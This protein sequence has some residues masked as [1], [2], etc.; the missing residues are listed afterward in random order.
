MQTIAKTLRA[1]VHNW[2]RVNRMAFGWSGRRSLHLLFLWILIIAGVSHGWP[3]MIVAV[4]IPG[5]TSPGRISAFLPESIRSRGYRH[6]AVHR[7]AVGC[8]RRRDCLR[9]FLDHKSCAHVNA[10]SASRGVR[11]PANR[12]IC[13]HAFRISQV[14]NGS[15]SRVGKQMS[16]GLWGRCEMPRRA[17]DSLQSYLNRI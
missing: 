2:S 15:D 1:A 14:R 4:Q 16:L 13:R 10:D 3:S 17:A 5:K 12:L 6:A 9:L 11:Q 8:P 7:G